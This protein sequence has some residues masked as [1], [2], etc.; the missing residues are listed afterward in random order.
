MRG[1]IIIAVLSFL[2]AQ[3]IKIPDGKTEYTG[4]QAAF[5]A[6]FARHKFETRIDGYLRVK[7]SKRT[8][9]TVEVKGGHK[10]A[11]RSCF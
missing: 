8:Q 1:R 10:F 9:A 5:C 7:T 6:N 2:R 4:C 11:S 3:T